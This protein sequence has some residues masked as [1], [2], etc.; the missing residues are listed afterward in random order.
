MNTLKEIRSNIQSF[1]RFI[2][3]EYLDELHP[4]RQLAFAHPFDRDDLARK[5]K[6]EG[7]ITEDELKAWK[8]RKDERNKKYNRD[9]KRSTN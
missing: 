3:N 5:L 4:L 6:N 8:H 2:T 9:G 1:N 7:I